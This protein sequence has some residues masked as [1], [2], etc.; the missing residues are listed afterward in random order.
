MNFSFSTCPSAAGSGGGGVWEGAGGGGGGW[1]LGG[2]V[3]G[4]WRLAGAAEGT[5][6]LLV[7]FCWGRGGFAVAAGAARGGGR[8]LYILQRA[9]LNFGILFCISFSQ[10]L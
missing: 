5:E 6:D 3:G 4:G 9:P 2:G 8:C 10:F 7:L 1:G